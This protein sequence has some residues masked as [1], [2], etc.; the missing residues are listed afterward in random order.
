MINGAQA[1]GDVV[2][3]KGGGGEGAA[4]VVVVVVGLGVT[5]ASRL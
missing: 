2:G 5:E 4:V 3:E 1:A